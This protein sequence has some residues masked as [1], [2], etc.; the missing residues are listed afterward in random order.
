MNIGN[1]GHVAEQDSSDW[2]DLALFLKLIHW[3]LCYVNHIH[4]CV[5]L[6]REL[7]GSSVH[8]SRIYF[9]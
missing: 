5:V 2:Y 3:P 8:L 9:G 6:L 7:K 4:T 1:V